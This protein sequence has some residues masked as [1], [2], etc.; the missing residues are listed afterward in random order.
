MTKGCLNRTVGST[1]M[2]PESSRSHCIVIISVR[3][4]LENNDIQ[5]GKLYVTDL[6]G[7]ERQKKSKTNGTVFDE[8]TN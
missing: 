3:K 1:E 8:G 5:I 6:A 4:P 7:N 2:N